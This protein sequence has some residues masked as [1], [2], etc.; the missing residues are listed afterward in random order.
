MRKLRFAHP[1][2]ASARHPTTTP[3]A[4]EQRT[5]GTATRSYPRRAVAARLPG[6]QGSRPSHRP[7]RFAC[8]GTRCRAGCPIAPAAVQDAP[9]ARRAGP[10]RCRPR[11]RG[12]RG[13]RRACPR[14]ARCRGPPRGAGRGSGACAARRRRDRGH[15]G[16]RRRRRSSPEA[17][18][19]RGQTPELEGEAHHPLPHRGVG[20]DAVGDVRGHVAHATRATARAQAA[21]LAREGHEDVVAA[22]VARAAHEAPGEVAAREGA[23]EGVLHVARQRRGVRCLG[24]RDEGGVV[25]VDEAVQDGVLGPARTYSAAGARGERPRAGGGAPGTGRTLCVMADLQGD[26]G[27]TDL[28]APWRVAVPTHGDEDSTRPEERGASPCDAGADA[29]A[30]RAGAAGGRDRRGEAGRSLACETVTL[31]AVPPRP[32]LHPI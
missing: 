6:L 11:A 4:V 13:H 7:R 21:L 8:R 14:Q 20:Q 24:V 2:P 17:G 23:L 32:Q 28:A 3:N 5:D 9:R 12:A 15:A 16:R 26:R 22:R 27:L 25:L 30:G 10:G 18:P 1:P 29:G 31:S 19:H